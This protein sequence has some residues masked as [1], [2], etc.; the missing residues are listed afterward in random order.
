[1]YIRVFTF[2]FYVYTYFVLFKTG[3]QQRD[4]EQRDIPE[5]SPA[6]EDGDGGSPFQEDGEFSMQGLMLLK[7]RRP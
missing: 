2:T 5:P 6:V 7:W 4:A 1:M 3:G